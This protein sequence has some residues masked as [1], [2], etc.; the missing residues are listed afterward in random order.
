MKKAAIIINDQISEF[1][2]DDYDLIIGVEKGSIF[3]YNLETNKQKYFISDFDSVS[4]DFKGKILTLENTIILNHETKRWSDGEEAILLAIDKGYAG[5]DIDIYV[6]TLGREDHFINM[7]MIL[8]KYG[9]RM[10]SNKSRFIILEP[11]KDYQINRDE[12]SFVSLVF[13]KQ[14]KVKTK[15]LKWE[16]DRGYDVSTGTNCISNEAKANL[17]SIRVDQKVLLTQTND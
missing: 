2:I 14:T 9:S 5:E 6:N 10:I 7:I 17:F 8:R 4:D 13:F 11:N 3:V 12:Y 1:K 15:G 16:I